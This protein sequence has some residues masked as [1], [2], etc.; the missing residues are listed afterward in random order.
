MLALLQFSEVSVRAPHCGGQKSY[1]YLVNYRPEN[2]SRICTS[3][4]SLG[5]LI[6]KVQ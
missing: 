1:S 2:R 4:V 5:A 3:L 6:L